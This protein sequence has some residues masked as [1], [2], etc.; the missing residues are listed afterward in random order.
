MCVNLYAIFLTY[1]DG[2]EDAEEKATANGE[3]D[4]NP[5]F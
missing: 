1:E 2:N 4:K 3:E 5:P